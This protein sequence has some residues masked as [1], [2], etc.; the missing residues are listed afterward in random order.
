MKSMNSAENTLIGIIPIVK[1]S[2]KVA[3]YTMLELNMNH[4]NTRNDSV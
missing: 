1:S 3:S 4:L 2:Q